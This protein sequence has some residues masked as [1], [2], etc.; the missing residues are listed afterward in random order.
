[1][2]KRYLPEQKGESRQRTNLG[3][4]V[5]NRLKIHLHQ[6]ANRVDLIEKLTITYDFIDD[7]FQSSEEEG[8]MA[9]KYL[10]E[11]FAYKD[12][13]LSEIKTILVISKP[14]KDIEVIRPARERLYEIYEAKKAKEIF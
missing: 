8:L 11:A 14:F 5:N 3:E 9:L 12:C 10:M 2:G 13:H 7:M 1:M 4:H 6:Y